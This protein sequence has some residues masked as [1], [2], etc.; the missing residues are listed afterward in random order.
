[1]RAERIAEGRGDF[2]GRALGKLLDLRNPAG[3]QHRAGRD[4]HQP[5]AAR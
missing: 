4:E 5:V 1:M 2:R 3:L